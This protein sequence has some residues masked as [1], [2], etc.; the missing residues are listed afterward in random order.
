[1]NIQAIAKRSI[2]AAAV[3]AVVMLSTT[4][5][6]GVPNTL[7]HQGRLYDSSGVPVTGSK[8]ITFT[9]Y[10]NQDDPANA[11][12]WKET[13]TVTF[14]NGHFAV[15]VGSIT[16]FGATLF[17]GSERFLGITVLGDVEMSPRSSIASVPYALVAGDVIGDIAPMSVSIPGFGEVINSSGQWVGDPTGLVGPIGPQGPMGLQ[18]SSGPQGPQGNTGPTGPQGIPGAQGPVGPIGPQG[19]GFMTL[20]TTIQG[21]DISPGFPTNTDLEVVFAQTMYNEL[22]GTLLGANRFV[23]PAS[24]LY[25][26]GVRADFCPQVTH[27]SEIAVWIDGIRHLYFWGGAVGG[28]RTL[29]HK[30]TFGLAQGNQLKVTVADSANNGGIGGIKLTI[31]RLR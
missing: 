8:T 13:H 2:M 31:I 15:S 10:A 1:M 3:L 28:C 4:A 24:G 18:G 6:A 17:D 7:N 22:P 20:I 5:N 27:G 14:D 30:E 9:I 16:P 12:L 23:I 25:E 19:P 11:Y 26:I 21:A 29:A